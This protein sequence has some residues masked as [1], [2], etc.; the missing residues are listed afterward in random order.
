MTANIPSFCPA[1][2]VRIVACRLCDPVSAGS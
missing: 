2:C 1:G